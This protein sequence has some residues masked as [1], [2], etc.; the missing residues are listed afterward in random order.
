M[1]LCMCCFYGQSKTQDKVFIEPPTS[2][3]APFALLIA[4]EW[5][6]GL[7]A[8]DDLEVVQWCVVAEVVDFVPVNVNTYT[9][10]V[11]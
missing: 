11:S 5:L 8:E 4:I 10:A 2:P 9:K 1:L 6:Q 3:L 7:L